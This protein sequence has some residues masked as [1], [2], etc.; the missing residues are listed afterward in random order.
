MKQPPSLFPLL[1]SEY[2]ILFL[3]L[4]VLRAGNPL[5]LRTRSLKA[6]FF[7]FLQE[8]SHLKYDYLLEIKWMIEPQETQYELV[9]GLPTFSSP[10][11]TQ[12]QYFYSHL[13]SEIIEK[14]RERLLSLIKHLHVNTH[15]TYVSSFN[16]HNRYQVYIFNIFWLFLLPCHQLYVLCVCLL[17]VSCSPPLDSLFGKGF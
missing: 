5:C 14:R 12:E 16:L 4:F 15:V 8:V 11:F 3:F 2:V 10:T 13:T 9:S 17:S 7:C 6:C 1:Q